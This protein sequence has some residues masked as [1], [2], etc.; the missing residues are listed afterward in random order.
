VYEFIALVT[1]KR[2]SFSVLFSS[3]IER[4]T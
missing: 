4:G 3:S 1:Q 2:G